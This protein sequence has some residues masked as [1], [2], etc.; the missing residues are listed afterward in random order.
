MQRKTE[1]DALLHHS[2]TTRLDARAWFRITGEDRVRWLNGMVT[3]SIQD[4][5]PGQGNYSFLLNAQGRI[6]GDVTIFA[7]AE[8]LLAETD[9]AQLDAVMRTLDHYIIMDDVAL[10]PMPES[11]RGLLLAGP[12]SA[13]LLAALGLGEEAASAAPTR[14]AVPWQGHSVELVHA[15]SPLVPRYELWGEAE[16]VEALGTA[17]TAAGAVACSDEALELLRLLEGTP[18]FGI[19]IRDKELPQETGQ[20]RALHF[21]KGCYLGQE[22]VERIRSRGNVHRVFQGFAL[23]GTLPAPGT[24]LES[25]GKPVGE[26]TSCADLP[27]A[28]SGLQLALGYVRREALERGSTLAYAGG[29][30]RPLSLPY[31]AARI[32]P[33]ATSQH[34]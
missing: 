12:H 15:H 9:T 10:E 31:T 28:G 7:E 13:G 2:G 16:V 23:Q 29:V 21:A 32:Q 6:Q 26:L 3:N 4:L 34:D 20:T 22:I 1:L 30:A 5:Q 33:D 8:A 25:E 27:L 18:R 14:R 17:A 11:R 19:D 24:V